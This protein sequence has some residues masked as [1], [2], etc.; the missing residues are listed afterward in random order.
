MVIWLVVVVVA[1]LLL[2]IA[3]LT[4]FPF[5]VGNNSQS[6]P[7]TAHWLIVSFLLH[8]SHT[9]WASFL[10]CFFFL[11]FF[12]IRLFSVFVIPFLYTLILSMSLSL[13]W[14]LPLSE[15]F[16]KDKLLIKE[17]NRWWTKVKVPKRKKNNTKRRDLLK[18]EKKSS[19]WLN[20]I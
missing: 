6:G 18:P 11:L 16:N 14:H 13:R 8:D 7:F 20:G 19:Q 17:K 2:V 12:V 15:A 10:F 4:Y 3:A 5:T 1:L 9:L